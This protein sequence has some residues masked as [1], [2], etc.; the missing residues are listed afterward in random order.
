[1]T[2]DYGGRSRPDWAIL[3]VDALCAGGEHVV[4]QGVASA[5][6]PW[7]IIE[8]DGIP[9]AWRDGDGP[10]ERSTRDVA[11]ALSAA[12]FESARQMATAQWAATAIE[13]LRTQGH[14]AT[15]ANLLD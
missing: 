11:A 10:D 8:L 7:P 1:M 5:P 9:M 4:T 13:T 2:A 15:I 6:S 3:T 12:G 14:F